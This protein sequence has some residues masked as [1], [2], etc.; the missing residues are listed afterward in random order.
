MQEALDAV[1]GLSSRR[2]PCRD[3]RNEEHER[4]EKAQT[5]KPHFSRRSL[6]VA[7]SLIG[8]VMMEGE[9]GA[10]RASVLAGLAPFPPA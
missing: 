9:M 7:I 1:S 10:R 8:I 5:S 6:S 3:L 2:I 4:E